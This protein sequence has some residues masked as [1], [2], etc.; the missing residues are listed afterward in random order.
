[1]KKGVALTL[2]PYSLVSLYELLCHSKRTKAARKDPPM[3]I[4]VGF[5][6]DSLGAYFFL[7]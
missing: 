4:L 6:I 2:P 7:T 1:M 5:I 3:S